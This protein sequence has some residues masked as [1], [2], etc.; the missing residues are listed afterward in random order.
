MNETWLKFLEAREV[1]ERV[2]SLIRTYLAREAQSIESIVILRGLDYDL[3]YDQYDLRL[4]NGK[5]LRVG[6]STYTDAYDVYIWLHS[7]NG[8]WSEKDCIYR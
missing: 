4:S 7:G 8:E 5:V 3:L 1:D 2:I 6:D